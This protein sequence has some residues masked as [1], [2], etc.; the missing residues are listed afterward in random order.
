MLESESSC[1]DEACFNVSKL[2]PD[3]RLA[4]AM[5]NGEPMPAFEGLA[6]AFAKA[7]A[8]T[9]RE[10]AQGLRATTGDAAEANKQG[11]VHFKAAHGIL[12]A[13]FTLILFVLSQG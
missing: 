1:S 10:E 8:E 13:F 9:E 4:F 2:E 6:A 7:K 12:V 3:V 11:E 5:D